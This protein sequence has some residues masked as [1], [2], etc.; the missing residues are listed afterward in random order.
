MIDLENNGRIIGDFLEI[1]ADIVQK[2]FK[3]KLPSFLA[4]I[5]EKYYRNKL[6]KRAKKMKN[7]NMIL[8]IYNIYELFVYTYNNFP[9]DGKY[10][11]IWR[12]KIMVSD[13]NVEAEAVIKFDNITSIISIDKNEETLDVNIL[14]ENNQYYTRC[15][16]L[17]KHSKKGSKIDILLMRINK[18]LLNIITDYIIETLEAYNRKDK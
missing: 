3:S 14:E 4:N 8:S 17:L 1:N 12:S 9:P 7:S 6:I 2:R 13:N 18:E 10:K 15:N 11:S 16:K 5:D